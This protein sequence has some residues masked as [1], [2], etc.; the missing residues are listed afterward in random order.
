[1]IASIVCALLIGSS[2]GLNVKRVVG[3]Q[4]AAEAAHKM[5]CVGVRPQITCLSKSYNWGMVWLHGLGN[6]KQSKINENFL[7]PAIMAMT[8]GGRGVSV[9]PQAPMAHVISD[10]ITE[11]SWHQQETKTCD[12]EYKPPSHGYSLMSGMQNVHI[13]H[14][15]IAK[16]MDLGIPSQ[17]IMLAGHSQGGSM[18]Y[19]SALKFP[20]KL[21]GAINLSGGLL[22]WWDIPKLIHPSGANEGMPMLW[23]KGDNDEVVPQAHQDEVMP[24]LKEAG[25]NPQTKY[26]KGGHD[27]SDPKIVPHVSGW[28]NRQLL[29]S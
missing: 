14:E 3:Q 1:M 23:L 28:I 24:H 19:L 9:F 26:F 22:G 27:L 8:G 15:Q 11:Q 17:K 10:N 18:V 20:E 21:M 25:F 6:G 2:Q 4:S 29:K 7:V 13:V 16:L 12:V 5:K